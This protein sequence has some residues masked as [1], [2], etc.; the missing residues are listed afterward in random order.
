VVMHHL[1]PRAPVH[2]ISIVLRG[3]Q[4][5]LCRQ[6]LPD[7]TLYVTRSQLQAALASAL[8]GRAAEQLVFGETSTAAEADIQKATDSAR[9]MIQEY[10][11]SDRLGKVALKP[12]PTSGLFGRPTSEPATYS[13]RTAQAVDEEIRRLLDEAFAQAAAIIAEHRDMLAQLAAELAQRETLEVAD[14]EC[15]F[16]SPTGESHR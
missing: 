13:D 16:T 2:K 11:M 7:D 6:L 5:H 14:L 3:T 8:G 12:A 10:G 9:K 4:G 15:I 1:A